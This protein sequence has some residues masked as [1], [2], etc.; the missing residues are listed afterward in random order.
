MERLTEEYNANENPPVKL[1]IAYGMAMF[2]VSDG[3]MEKSVRLADQRMYECKRIKKLKA[4]QTT[5]QGI[6]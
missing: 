6:Q 2:T 3:N 4:T 5:E 1:D